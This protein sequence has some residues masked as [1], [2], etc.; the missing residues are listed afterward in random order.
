MDIAKFANSTL[1]R[2][3]GSRKLVLVV[4]LAMLG[5]VLMIFQPGQEGSRA[6]GS[7]E[8][9]LSAYGDELESR[10]AELCESVRGVSGVRV[11][12]YFDSGFETVYAY[13]E[14][15]KTTSGGG[16][17]IEK[18]YVTIGSGSNES[19][20]CIVERMPSICGVAVVCRGGG[21]SEISRELIN[22][23]SSAYGVPKNKIY[24]AEGKK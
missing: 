1:K 10:I 12:V 19:M 24:V 23:I 16:L 6:E 15:S 9:R 13:N 21:S 17:S 14:E 20:V 4:A 5:V 2:S 22:L 11:S 8:E 18:K 7:D 3:G